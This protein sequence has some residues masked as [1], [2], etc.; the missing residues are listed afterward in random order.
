MEGKY[1][2]ESR[3]PGAHDKVSTRP[4]ASSE[5]QP[6]PVTRWFPQDVRLGCASPIPQASKC[7]VLSSRP[8]HRWECKLVRP[9]QSRLGGSSDTGD[10]HGRTVSSPTWEHHRSTQRRLRKLSAPLCARARP[11]SQD[12]RP[13]ACPSPA[14]VGGVTPLSTEQEEIPGHRADWSQSD[15]S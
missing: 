2:K 7:S 14:G 8:R 6:Q 3:N 5:G 4:S 12:T 9:L 11:N 15:T 13:P 10:P 1:G